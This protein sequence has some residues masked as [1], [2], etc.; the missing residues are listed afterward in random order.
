MNIVRNAIRAAGDEGLVTLR[1]RIQRQITIGNDRH[2]LVVQLEV[3]DNG[4][5]ISPDML[6]KIFYPMVSASEGGMGLGLSIAQS[7]ISQHAGLIECRSRPGE[8]VFT[9]LLP[10]ENAH[11]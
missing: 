3:E 2:R 9:V 6:E 8:T 10:L 7:L 11:A 5:G 1:T 4:P